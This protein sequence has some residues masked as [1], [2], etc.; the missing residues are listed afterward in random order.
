MTTENRNNPALEEVVTW[1]GPIG[2]KD[3]RCEG[4]S[5]V[6]AIMVAVVL[7]RGLVIVI[8]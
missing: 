4:R 7:S 1:S 2:D 6:S 5:M 3:T 8:M